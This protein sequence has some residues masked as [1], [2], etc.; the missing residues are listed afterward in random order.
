MLSSTKCCS[1]GRRRVGARGYHRLV[2]RDG[3]VA[4][5]G[6]YIVPDGIATA[7]CGSRVAKPWEKI[8]GLI[9]PRESDKGDE[10]GGCCARQGGAL[11]GGYHECESHCNERCGA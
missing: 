9:Q 8:L 11:L 2:T 4:S 7:S 10:V 3:C 5:P 6:R 1:P